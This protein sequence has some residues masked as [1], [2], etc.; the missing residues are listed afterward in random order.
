MEGGVIEFNAEKVEMELGFKSKVKVND[1]HN[2]V[3]HVCMARGRGK[4]TM[5]ALLK[6]DSM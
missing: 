1:I 6:V 3:Q 2:S 5:I 4:C